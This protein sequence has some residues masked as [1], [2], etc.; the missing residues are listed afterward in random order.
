MPRTVTTDTIQA[1]DP[2]AEME[3]PL[4]ADNPT[5]AA[6]KAV[7]SARG[8]PGAPGAAISR[9]TLLDDANVK[10]EL[11]VESKTITPPP[12]PPPPPPIEPELVAL[13]LSLS[14][15][16]A[17]GSV[18]AVATLLSATNP[19]AVLSLSS[20][21]PNVRVPA[22]VTFPAGERQAAFQ[23]STDVAI[24]A[25]LTATIKVTLGAK[26]LTAVLRVMAKPLPPPP[27]GPLDVKAAGLKG[28]GLTDDGPA[29]QKLLDERP[30]GQVLAFPAGE[31]RIGYQV[32]VRKAMTL[33]G[34]KGASWLKHADKRGLIVGTP[35][36]TISGAVLDGMGFLGIP[37]RF[38][39]GGNWTHALI[40]HGTGTLVKNCVVKGSG[41]GFYSV[42][43]G[44][45][46][47]V[48]DCEAEG[49]GSVMIGAF[50]GTTVKRCR[51]VQNDPF[52]GEPPRS[53]HGGYLHTGSRN[54]L[55]EDVT[56][57]NV[58]KYGI[59]VYGESVGKTIEDT[60]LR[61]V[62]FDGCQSGIT[63]VGFPKDASRAKRV[64][65]EGCKFLRTVGIA[66]SLKSGDDITMTNCEI[67]RARD[68]LVLG[69]WAPWEADMGSLI[70]AKISGTKI[71]NCSQRGL[72]VTKG[73]GGLFS[74]CVVEG[75]VYGT[76]NLKNYYADEPPVA[77]VVVR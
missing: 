39:D 55:F 53:S 64:L 71:S 77:G 33:K 13:N 26:S 41:N 48:E 30:E 38:M 75:T 74:E 15:V 69:G 76:G 70:R 4:D 11:V 47:T 58:R 25:D 40:D 51:F 27:P 17:G 18:T 23:V 63:V 60:I 34:T 14:T 67:D 52:T 9:T 56:F 31:Y 19:Q 54:V 28:D 68:G 62:T 45:G 6:F 37:G 5:P 8:A 65:M 42:F 22:S 59:Q 61:R 16:T 21:V 43:P 7:L 32:Y 2:Y 36:A 35:E 12:P 73:A 44:S 50:V 66:V 46:M 1:A 49:W 72:V 57:V 29:L 3:R 10:A 24:T 20:N